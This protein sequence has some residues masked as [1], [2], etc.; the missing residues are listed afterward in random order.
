MDTEDHIKFLSALILGGYKKATKYVSPILV[1]KA[2]RVGK[3]DGRNKSISF[4]VTAG[5]PNYAEK[6]FIKKSIASKKLFPI[7]KIRLK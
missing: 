7:K 4:V 2:T 3:L 6:I 5:R 1:I